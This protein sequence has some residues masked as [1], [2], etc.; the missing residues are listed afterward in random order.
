VVATL[1]E[2]YTRIIKDRKAWAVS[3]L[4]DIE[5]LGTGVDQ[6]TGAC[7]SPADLIWKEEAPWL[8][9]Q[10]ICELVKSCS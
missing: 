8:D 5:E 1:A 2:G 4:S 7:P 9:V 6:G 10:K 3:A